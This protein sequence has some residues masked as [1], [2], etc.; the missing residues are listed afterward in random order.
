VASEKWHVKGEK[1]V[2]NKDTGIL[3]ESNN[4]EKTWRFEK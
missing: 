2:F 3:P 4:S 1:S